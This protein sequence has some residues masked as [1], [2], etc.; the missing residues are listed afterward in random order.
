M[1]RVAVRLGR[2]NYS[3]QIRNLGV[4]GVPGIENQS[5]TVALEV[6]DVMRSAE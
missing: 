5:R 4:L 2:Q 6:G 1:K 3:V